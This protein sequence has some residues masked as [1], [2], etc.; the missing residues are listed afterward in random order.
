MR[1][2]RDCTP[3]ARRAWIPLA[4]L[5][6]AAA[7]LPGGAG[8]QTRP[9]NDTGQTQCFDASNASVACNAAISGLPGQDGRYGRDAAAA[10]G[11]LVK[12]GAGS[13]GFDFTRLCMNGQAAGAGTC[14][15]NPS[16]N[17]GAN[18]TATEWACTRD[19]VTGL[20]WSLQT[21]LEFW[22]TAI[23]P[24]FAATGHNAISR[25]GSATGWRLPTNA[26][27][28]TLATYGGSNP[29]IDSSHFP[30][31]ADFPY[32]TST[33]GTA[34]NTAWAVD[35]ATGGNNLYNTLGATYVRLVLPSGL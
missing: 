34:S 26:E 7:G 28:L 2:H 17:T 23:T 5:A 35:F 20:V 19:N 25:C 24:A 4:A 15:A 21:R 12:Q 9:L 16:Y 6:L 33:P 8:A 3:G 22:D 29:A 1:D 27:L 32:W 30:D 10:A 11:V 13:A 18:P 31:T 14:P